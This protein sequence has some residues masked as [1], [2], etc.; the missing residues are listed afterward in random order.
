M[1]QGLPVLAQFPVWDDLFLDPDSS[2][3]AQHT[4]S[5]EYLTFNLLH[6]LWL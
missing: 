5:L 3:P 1:G 2:N 4:Y 6:N